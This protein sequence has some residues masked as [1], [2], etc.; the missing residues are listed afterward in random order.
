M[1]RGYILLYNQYRSKANVLVKN[2]ELSNYLHF[3]LNKRERKKKEFK[4][5]KIPQR[6]THQWNPL[7]TQMK[8]EWCELSLA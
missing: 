8:K 1:R 7:V 5:L 6:S 4:C 2:L 3:Q